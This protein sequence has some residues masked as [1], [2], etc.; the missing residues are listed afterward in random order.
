MVRERDFARMRYW[1]LIRQGHPGVIAVPEVQFKVGDYVKV[2]GDFIPGTIDGDR[3]GGHGETGRHLQISEIFN[4]LMVDWHTHTG[5]VRLSDPDT[6]ARVCIAHVSHLALSERPQLKDKKDF[7]PGTW[8]HLD[9]NPE[10]FYYI[11]A[12]QGGALAHQIRLRTANAS[13]EAE[14]G[15]LTATYRIEKAKIKLKAAE[16]FRIGATIL[17]TTKKRDACHGARGSVL[18]KMPCAQG[19][20]LYRVFLPG[21]DYT[22]LYASE[23]KLDPE[24]LVPDEHGHVHEWQIKWDGT[25]REC[26]CGEKNWQLACWTQGQWQSTAPGRQLAA[27]RTLD[28]KKVSARRLRDLILEADG[29]T[30]APHRTRSYDIIPEAILDTRISIVGAGAIGSF[31]ALGLLKMGFRNLILWD[32]DVVAVENIGTQLYGH[33]DIG[34]PKVQALK[35]WLEKAGPENT[36]GRAFRITPIHRRWTLAKEERFDDDDNSYEEWERNEE[37]IVIFAVDSMAARKEIW[38]S[39]RA[40]NFDSDHDYQ[41]AWVVDARM[42]AEHLSLYTMKPGVDGV[43]PDG[44][45]YRKSLYSDE[46]ALQE[47]CTAAGTAYT[48]FAAATVVC[49]AVKDV[50]TG[51]PKYARILHWNIA[52]NVQTVYHRQ[53][54][55]ED[56]PAPALTGTFDHIRE[57]VRQATAEEERAGARY[58]PILQPLLPGDQVFTPGGDLI[59][60]PI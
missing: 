60:R 25:Y 14:H 9:S 55:V 13:I 2:I 46:N 42:G 47:P 8:V 49:K 17:V 39:I 3:I 53:A 52:D 28:G 33:A 58:R 34:K 35:A 45:T 6:A 57:L 15:V 19:G 27:H 50:L 38:D 24:A 56:L 11:T 59:Y 10:N 37:G 32:H 36:R 29:W 26:L 1:S 48:A 20:D 22:L 43:D 21:R 4:E 41:V 31:T 44:E 30:K 54:P 12:N 51:N 18:G 40:F 7:P 16:P 5:M 23:M